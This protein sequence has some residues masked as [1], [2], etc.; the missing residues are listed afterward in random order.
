M[1]H[2]SEEYFLGDR[3]A[4]EKHSFVLYEIPSFAHKAIYSIL[5]RAALH[6]NSQMYLSSSIFATEDQTNVFITSLVILTV[7]GFFQYVDL[8]PSQHEISSS[9]TIN[10]VKLDSLFPQIGLNS[11][12]LCLLRSYCTALCT[13]LISTIQPLQ[14]LD[15]APHPKLPSPTQRPNDG[16]DSNQGDHRQR[17]PH[18]DRGRIRM[19][20]TAEALDRD[21]L[22]VK[23]RDRGSKF[24]LDA[25]PDVLYGQCSFLIPMES[26]KLQE[27][28]TSDDHRCKSEGL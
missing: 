18:D 26:L 4:Y 6:T 12:E 20:C 8:T 17:A 28:T 24:L 19:I 21:L 15:I 14:D 25:H 23:L 27:M 2:K 11:F 5:L 13:E 3:Q 22:T 10:T 1:R 9:T 16:R 7:K